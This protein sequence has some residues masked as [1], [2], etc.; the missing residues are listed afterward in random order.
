RLPHTLNLELGPY[1]NVLRSVAAVYGR[2]LPT[3]PSNVPEAAWLAQTQGHLVLTERTYTEDSL[4]AAPM[5]YRLPVECEVK[6]FEVTG[7]A[8]PRAGL[9]D[10][11]QLATACAGAEAA[12]FEVVAAD[13]GRVRKRL[14]EDHRV[15]YAADDLAS[16]LPFR[17]A[18]RLGLAQA[19]YQLALTYPVLRQLFSPTTVPDADIE[20]ILGTQARY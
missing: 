5:P 6:T 8:P 7:L 18:S 9:L 17:Q 3:R 12:G 2:R 13:E 15:L 16:P 4:T 1:G 19:S 10:L 14:I 20:T 11:G